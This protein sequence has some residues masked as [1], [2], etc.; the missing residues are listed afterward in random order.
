MKRIS[1]AGIILA[2]ALTPTAT[3]TSPASAASTV[4]PEFSR[5][6]SGAGTSGRGSLNMEGTII[7]CEAG[8]GV[9]SAT[10]TKLGTFKLTITQCKSG[11][12]ACHSLGQANSST[13]EVTGEYHLVSLASDRTFYEIWSLLGSDSAGALHIECNSEAVGLILIWG[14]ILGQIIETANHT[15]QGIL[16]TEGGGKTIK[17][18]INTYGNNTGTEITAEGLRGKL[19]TGTERKASISAEENLGHTEASILE[20]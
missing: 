1:V 7:S 9:S 18:T 20:S 15:F 5:S 14:N 2:A 19:G 13:V 6:A 4:L 8:T 17:Q 10:S 12:E 11:G 16:K 3:A